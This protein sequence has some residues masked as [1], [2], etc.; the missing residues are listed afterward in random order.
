MSSLGRG[1]MYIY[2]Y[3]YIWVNLTALHMNDINETDLYFLALFLA[4]FVNFDVLVIAKNKMEP[5]K[6]KS[7]PHIKQKQTLQKLKSSKHKLSSI[8]SISA[9][10]ARNNHYCILQNTRT[11]SRAMDSTK[12]ESE[13]WKVECYYYFVWK[14]KSCSFALCS[15][16]GRQWLREEG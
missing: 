10:G 5:T 2:I 7:R 3:I 4:D 11:S 9:Q 12:F 8:S 15:V 1:V 16:L 13:G 14:M 6:W